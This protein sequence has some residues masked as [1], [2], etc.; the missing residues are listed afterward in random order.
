ML[1]LR[2]VGPRYQNWMIVIAL[3]LMLPGMFTLDKEKGI[4]GL[5]RTTEGIRNL[6]K[7]KWRI[8]MIL[9]SMVFLIVWLPEVWFICK[10]FDLSQW[11]APLVSIQAFSQ[12]PG[13]LPI[14]LEVVGLWLYRY[15][16]A[17]ITCAIVCKSGEKTGKY[18]PSVLISGLIL[19]VI[20]FLLP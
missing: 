7:T 10:A 19:G 9:S 14:W 18:I 15:A 20:L 4:H 17:M 2:P 5:L 6:R 12:H 3:S 13:W 16:V 1:G 11:T 8:A